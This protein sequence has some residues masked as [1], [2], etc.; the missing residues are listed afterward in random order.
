MGVLVYD[1]AKWGLQEYNVPVVMLSRLSLSPFPVS[2]HKTTNNNTSE[3]YDW[4]LNEADNHE[5]CTLYHNY[6]PY[7]PDIIPSSYST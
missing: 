2:V 1:L 4:R 5:K 3:F 7:P 6:P